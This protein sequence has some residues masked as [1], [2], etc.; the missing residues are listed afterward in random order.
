MPD[1]IHIACAA[2]GFAG[3]LPEDEPRQA[4][5]FQCPMCG[6]WIR[7]YAAEVEAA[8]RL[9]PEPE[10]DEESPDRPL[11]GHLVVSGTLTPEEPYPVRGPK[12]VVGRDEADITIADPT[13]SQR[14]FEIETRG[15]ELFIRDLGSTNHT[16]VNGR[17]IQAT[18]LRSGD[19]IQAGLTS[20]VFHAA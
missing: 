9:E 10:P 12:T 15:G 7:S 20:F 14:H 18:T 16:R 17:A 11:L 5:A 4:D 19:R 2:C 6:T 13:M 8:S 1:A 3:E